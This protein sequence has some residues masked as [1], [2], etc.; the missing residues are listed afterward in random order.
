MYR[1]YKKRRRRRKKITGTLRKQN[2]YV[3]EVLV[4]SKLSKR[5]CAKIKPLRLS[6]Q[7]SSQGLSSRSR[8]RRETLGTRSLSEKSARELPFPL[9]YWS[10]GQA[11]DVSV[12]NQKSDIF[13][14]CAIL[15]HVS[16]SPRHSGQ[17]RSAC[18]IMPDL[19]VKDKAVTGR[20]SFK[21]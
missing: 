12:G 16:T 14:V 13:S 11:S 2:V 21:H 4:G 15:L 8:G 9:Y 20:R 5:T 3:A 10:L 7:P 19:F 6:E 1:F 17:T 18:A